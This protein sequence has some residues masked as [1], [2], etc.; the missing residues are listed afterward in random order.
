MKY[1]AEDVY[2]ESLK[3]LT[4]MDGREALGG[5]SIEQVIPDSLSEESAVIFKAAATSTELPAGDKKTEAL[6]RLCLDAERIFSDYYSKKEDSDSFQSKAAIIFN[7]EDPLERARAVT[8]LWSPELLV[9]DDEIFSSWK[10]ASVKPNP[11][12]YNPSEILIQLNALYSPAGDTLPSGISSKLSDAYAGFIRSN[13]EK[14]AVYDHPVPIFTRGAGH[15]LE[16][17]LVELDADIAYEKECGVFPPDKK[18]NVLI[19]IS[20]THRGLDTVCGIWLKE[21]FAELDIKHL[22]CYLLSESKARELD[23][24]L[25][26][27][28]EIFT[29]QGKY[30]CHFGALKYAQL[31]FEKSCGTRAGFKLDTDEGIHSRDMKQASG[32][33]WLEQLCHPYWGGTAENS[34]GEPVT[35]GFNIGEYVDSRDLDSLGYAEAIRTPEVKRSDDLRGPLPAVQQGRMPGKGYSPS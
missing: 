21:V 1:S 18:L 31:I 29:V 10:L 34:A 32:K 7:S 5:T 25:G 2:Y 4:G 11:A 33:T 19:S 17:C 24:L 26:S 28:T 20:T 14:I 30:A 13:P 15:E 23:Q 27:S 22:N 35:L 9:D 16:N 12:P 3:Q 8:E 6:R